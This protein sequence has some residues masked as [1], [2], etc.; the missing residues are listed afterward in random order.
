MLLV[1]L[2]LK[3]INRRRCYS[4]LGILNSNVRRWTRQEGDIELLEVLLI[5]FAVFVFAVFINESRRK[6]NAIN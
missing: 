5:F 6:V 1:L 2:T 4:L 3:L